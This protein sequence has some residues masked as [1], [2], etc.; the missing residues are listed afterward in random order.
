MARIRIK[1]DLVEFEQDLR[2]ERDLSVDVLAKY[3][4]QVTK[5]HREIATLRKSDNN[6]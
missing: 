3:F 2:Q 5:L 1:T 6:Q 4:E